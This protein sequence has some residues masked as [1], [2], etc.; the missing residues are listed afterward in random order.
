MKKIYKGFLRFKDYGESYDVLFLSSIEDPFCEELDDL[1]SGKNITLS[2]Y[3][4]EKEMTKEQ[5]QEGFIKTLLGC[6][7]S[8]FTE[9]YSE[10]TGYLWTDEELKVG[11]HDLLSEL[12]SYRDRYLIMEIEIHN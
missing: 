8:E 12:S 7:E 10:L 1:I 5:A 3:I 6:A 9:R 11:G 4:C 2:Y